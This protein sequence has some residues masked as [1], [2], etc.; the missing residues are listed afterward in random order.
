M[1]VWRIVHAMICFS[2]L[3]SRAQKTKNKKK[4]KYRSAEGVKSRRL[5]KPYKKRS[6]K[7][8]WGAPELSASYYPSVAHGWEPS[9][10][11]PL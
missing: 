2:F 6:E 4:K 9:T 11:T 7:G 10:L 5:H 3:R 1:D 8:S